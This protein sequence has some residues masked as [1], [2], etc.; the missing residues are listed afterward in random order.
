M[1]NN[2]KC[3]LDAYLSK[4]VLNLLLGNWL[5]PLLFLSKDV[6][7]LRHEWKT[8]TVNENRIL[9][10]ILSFTLL[11]FLYHIAKS[12]IIGRDY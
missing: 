9:R 8:Q 1:V 2:S 12:C 5:I 6:K 3:Y 11:Y 4:F 7:V 10:I